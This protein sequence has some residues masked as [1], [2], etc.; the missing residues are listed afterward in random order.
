[1]GARLALEDWDGAEELLRKAL[2]NERQHD[3]NSNLLQTYLGAQLGAAELGRGQLDEA[4]ALLEQA[5]TPN[6]TLWA[7]NKLF[8]LDH[9]V[10]LHERDAS[11]SRGVAS[12][13][14]GRKPDRGQVREV[15]PADG[16]G[17]PLALRR[18]QLHPWACKAIWRRS[19]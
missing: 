3:P 18:A 7:V 16:S 10:L 8:I 4:R 5:W 13:L 11:L 2:E 12:G 9:L 17:R 19:T 1:M 15:P 14:P 6:P